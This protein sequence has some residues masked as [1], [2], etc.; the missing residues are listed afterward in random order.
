[1]HKNLV[2]K[3]HWSMEISVCAL[4]IQT[5][6]QVFTIVPASHECDGLLRA[7]NEERKGRTSYCTT[8]T[9]TRLSKQI[10]RIVLILLNTQHVE[11]CLKRL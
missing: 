6:T 1:M 2:V 3:V 8:V 11:K 9:D 4:S 5:M 7:E 10:V